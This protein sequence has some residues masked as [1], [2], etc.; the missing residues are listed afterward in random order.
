MCTDGD[1]CLISL[2]DMSGAIA[3]LLNATYGGKG[4]SPVLCSVII[5]EGRCIEQSVM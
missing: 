1:M 2:T 5:I 4:A 3:K